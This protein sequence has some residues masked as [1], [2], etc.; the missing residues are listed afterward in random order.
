MTAIKCAACD[1]ELVPD[2]MGECP[3]G[4]ITC[5]WCEGANVRYVW[6]GDCLFLEECDACD[7]GRMEI[8]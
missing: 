4:H 1:F 5:Y 8:G 7:G 6:R 2:D 3:C